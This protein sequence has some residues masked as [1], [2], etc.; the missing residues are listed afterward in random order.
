MTKTIAW[1]KQN[2]TW[3]LRTL[4]NERGTIGGG[5]SSFVLV[6]VSV[7]IILLAGVGKINWPGMTDSQIAQPVSMLQEDPLVQAV[8]QAVQLGQKEESQR[9]CIYWRIDK[10]GH[11]T[12]TLSRRDFF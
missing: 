9:A 6:G 8:Q 10:H 5:A 1:W 7:G 3:V 4:M 11:F 2:R 12:T